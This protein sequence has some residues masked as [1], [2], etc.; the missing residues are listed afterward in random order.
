[1]SP[2]E[3]TIDRFEDGG[4]ALLAGDRGR[5][6]AVPRG[7]LPAQAREGDV[8]GLTDRDPSP[9]VRILEFELD[10]DA[11]ADQRARATQLRDALPRGPKGDI[12]L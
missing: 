9:T 5:T 7:W 11:R 12:A 8:I 2:K 6:F 1:M 10:P 4:W 3:Y